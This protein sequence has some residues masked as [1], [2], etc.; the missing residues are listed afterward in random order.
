MSQKDAD[1]GREPTIVVRADLSPIV[2]AL[3]RTIVAMR[4]KRRATSRRDKV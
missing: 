3:W 1:G 2:R 4:R